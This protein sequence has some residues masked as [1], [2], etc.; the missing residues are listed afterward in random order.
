MPND[1]D[2]K[3]PVKGAER[4]RQ[5]EHMDEALSKKCVTG[6]LTP[7]TIITADISSA[8]RL[9]GKGNICRI[10]VTATTYVAF[11]DD[12]LA[13][14]SVA[15]SPGLELFSAGTYLIA[16]RANFIRASAAAARLE[17]LPG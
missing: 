9:V 7:G 8:P 5:D 15:T 10:R 17:I 6:I 13:A 1:I 4:V 11:G 12:S 2:R 14:V 3:K 16:A